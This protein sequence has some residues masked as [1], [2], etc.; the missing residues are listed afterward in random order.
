VN[1]CMRG[2][3]SVGMVPVDREGSSP[4]TTESVVLF[5]SPLFACCCFSQV[6]IFE[7]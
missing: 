7:T 3:G 4:D 2:L 6:M 1:E 5:D